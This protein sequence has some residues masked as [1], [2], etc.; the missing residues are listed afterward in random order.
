MR[1]HGWQS[2]LHTLQ[3]VAITFYCLLVAAFYS[4]LGPLLGNRVAENTVLSLFSFVALSVM[5]FFIRCTAIDPSDKTSL[6]KKKA[7]EKSY[8]LPKLNYW[9]ILVQIFHRFFRK[10][11]RKI[12]RRFIRRRYMDPWFSPV[13]MDPF[14]PFLLLAKDEVVTPEAKGDET[15]FCSL[16]NIEVKKNSKHCK[17]CNRCV[18]GFDHHCRWL[19]NCIGKKN[20]TTFILMMVFV[21]LMLIIEGGSG[22]AIFVRCFADHK[23]IVREMKLKHYNKFPTGLLAAIAACIT[24]LTA[25]TS[26]ALGQLFFFH[27]VL[28]RKGM[29]TYDY[30]LAMRE[31]RE[32]TELFYDSDSSSDDDFELDS[33]QRSSFISRFIC[34]GCQTNQTRRLSIRIDLSSDLSNT[35]N[36]NS[37]PSIN[38]WRLLKMSK[39][40]AIMA[41]EKARERIS[42]QPK[43]TENDVK[44]DS[45]KPEEPQNMKLDL[46][47]SQILLTP[48]PL[49]RT[50]IFPAAFSSPRRRIS[51]SPTSFSGKPSALMIS[52]RQSPLHSPHKYK[53]HFEPKLSEVSR[54][55][56]SYISQQVLG[57]IL[58]K[59]RESSGC[60]S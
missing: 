36:P 28:I 44:I 18:E 23:G 41:A 57:S 22:I 34:K 50:L 49:E 15:T 55:L 10:I 52:R 6:K 33:P 17:S 43:T 42:N 45:T 11:E 2:P 8:G 4:F 29:R 13:Q 51:S 25:Y 59:G 56:E 53:T 38:P 16:C 39:E 5:V 47:K 58:K 60:A 26:V 31:E 19:N 12:L 14:V 21:M 9:G 40:K 24:V 54:Q 35:K 30:I 20:Y 37:H 1:R 27:V 48:L 3:I 32:A 7:G 46:I